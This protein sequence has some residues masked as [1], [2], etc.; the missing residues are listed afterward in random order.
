MM[1]AGRIITCVGSSQVADTGKAL[2]LQWGGELAMSL[3][4]GEIP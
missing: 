1:G 4:E 3:L 2:D